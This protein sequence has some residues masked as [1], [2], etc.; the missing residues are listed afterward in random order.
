MG[1]YHILND[2][3]AVCTYCHRP[4]I[5]PDKSCWAYRIKPASGSIK[6]FCTWSCLQAH[7]RGKEV[8]HMTLGA[9]IKK[10]RE[11][12]GWS[13]HH[14]AVMA[15]VDVK[16]LKLYESDKVRPGYASL[17][18]ICAGFGL[19]PNDLIPDTDYKD[20]S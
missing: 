19:T 14:C 12:R 7:R 13:L 10:N 16:T 1:K 5:I 17:C 6:Y 3:D 4:F 15:G 9:A 8:K 18:K 20:R 11:A 2:T